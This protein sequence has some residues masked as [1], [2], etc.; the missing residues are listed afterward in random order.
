MT[1]PGTPNRRV[2][3]QVRHGLRDP[4]GRADWAELYALSTLHALRNP[5]FSDLERFCFFIGY[6][7]SGHTLIG[8]ALNAHPEMVIS[9]ELDA[10]S[11]VRHGFRRSQLFSSILERDRHF[12]IMGRTW[13]GYPYQVPGQSQGTF[14]HL[15]I[16][17]DKRA[18]SSALQI[19][20]RPELLD[21]LRRVVR[22][23]I[24]VLHVT[25]NP[26]DNIATEARRHKLSLTDATA[27]YARICDA[28][29]VVR[30]LLDPSELLDVRYEA[31]A[32][33][34]EATLA[35]ICSFLG[36]EAAASYLQACAGIVWPSP[37]RS[38]DAVAWTADERR[39]V[40]QLIEKHGA[41]VSY[42]FDE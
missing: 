32:T 31:F 35:G 38:R 6:S 34:P 21:R 10:V 4:R 33:G 8:T 26:F 7:R 15:R 27:W 17:G 25:R 23:P 42:T 16:I 36:V 20:G 12:G 2:P 9:H 3:R 24:R 30:P 19:S 13:S 14:D 5:D 37:N 41:L 11:Y 29:S 1:S 18:R 39:G 28:I 40:E 22:V